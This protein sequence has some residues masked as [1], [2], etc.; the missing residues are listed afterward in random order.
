MFSEFVLGFSAEGIAG[1]SWDVDE[2]VCVVCFVHGIGEYAG[3]YERIAEMFGAS[4]IAALGMDLPGHGCSKGARGHCAPRLE[5]LRDIDSLLLHAESQYPGK[6]LILYGHSMGGNI[7]LDYRIR[8]SL[9]GKPCAYVITSPWIRLVNE[10][11]LPLY[12]TAKVLSKVKPDFALNS[13]IK[14]EDLGNP[15]VI[16]AEK[17]AELT[18]R[19][20]SAGTAVDCVDTG[21]AL[22]GG[23]LKGNGGGLG[24]PLLIMHGTGDKICD[25]NSTRRLAALEGGNCTYIEWDGLFHEIHNGNLEKDGKEVIEAVIG[26]LLGL[27]EVSG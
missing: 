14:P 4:R 8:G 24:K 23:S 6:P 18:H 9:S 17:R 13:G 11:P 15:D 25:I 21:K 26:W 22:L 19:R 12:L 2:P 5:V 16:K 7:A 20:I 27:P 10:I 1:Y 3:R